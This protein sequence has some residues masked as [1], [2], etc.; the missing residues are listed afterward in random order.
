LLIVPPQ[1]NKF[2]LLDLAPGKSLIEYAVKNGLQVFVISWRNPTPA[3]RDWGL[4]TYVASILDAIDATCGITGSPDVNVL[5]AGAGGITTMAM[6]AHLA[7]KDDRRVNAVSLL[8]AL[9][10]TES[11]SLVGSFATREAIALARRR[12]HVKGVLAGEEIGR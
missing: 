6:L 3:Q 12:S 5:A 4:D 9:L 10:D 8:V 11:E 7:A 2:Y 1:I